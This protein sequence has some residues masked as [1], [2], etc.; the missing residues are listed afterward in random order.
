MDVIYNPLETKLLTMAKACGCVTIS[1]LSMFVYQG[2]EQFRLWTGI[3][4]PVSTMSRVVKKALSE[5]NEE[6]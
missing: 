4:P 1:G 5:E 6:D 2:A 3:N